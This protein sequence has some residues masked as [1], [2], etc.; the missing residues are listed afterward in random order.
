MTTFLTKLFSSDFIPHGFCYLWDPKTLW[1]N[2]VSDG[3]IALAY[4]VIPVTLMYFVRRRQDLPFHWMFYLFGLFI[5]G[6][7]TTHLMEVW[8]VWNGTY[9]LAGVIKAI[10]AAASLATAGLLIPLVPKALALPSSAQLQAINDKLQQEVIERR[11]AECALQRAQDELEERVRQRTE[12]LARANNIL[13][14]EIVER[15]WAEESLRES[16][17]RYRELARRAERIREQERTRISREIHDELGQSLTAV[18]MDLAQL[19]ALISKDV[20]SAIRQTRLISNQL[21]SSMDMV[22]RIASDL[23]P[24]NLDYLGLAAA[25]EWHVKE[26]EARTGIQSNLKLRENLHL[27]TEQATVLFRI[28]QETLTNVARHAEAS[29]VSVQLDEGPEGVI[30]EITDDGKGIE[31][32]RVRDLKSIGILG[33]QERA[34][35]IG[36]TLEIL[37]IP[38]KG[39]SVRVRIPGRNSTQEPLP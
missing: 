31:D 2:A 18:K 22:R 11:R 19:S 21:D 38:G 10:T 30:L 36:G 5:F 7:G 32:S 35:G 26:F 23:R 34:A 14:A 29:S 37:G 20:D 12:E 16:E 24:R 27:N 15:K 25:I 39:T 4:Y 3:L 6:C 9:R 28:L 8:T 13:Q 1:L 17:Y 33:M